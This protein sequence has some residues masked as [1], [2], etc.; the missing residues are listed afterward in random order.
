MNNKELHFKMLMISGL[1]LLSG[2]SKAVAQEYRWLV[3][4]NQ[5]LTLWTTALKVKTVQFKVIFSWPAQYG[6][7]QYDSRRVWLGRRIL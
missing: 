4:V 5:R 7:N 3:L 1:I 2:A 6:D